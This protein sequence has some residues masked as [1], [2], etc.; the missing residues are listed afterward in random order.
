VVTFGYIGLYLLAAVWARA[1]NIDS[2]VLVWFPPA[3][4]AIAG[5]WFFG[6]RLLPIAIVAELLS[7]IFVFDV[8]T[9]FGASGL[10]VNCTLIPV[11]YGLGAELLRW[12]HFDP[13][14]ARFHDALAFMGLG[15][16][17]ASA[18]ASTLGIAVQVALGIVPRDEWAT[19]AAVFFVGDVVGIAGV[20]PVLLIVG[21]ALRRKAPFPL[22]DRVRATPGDP[23]VWA[24]VTRRDVLVILEV[25]APSVIAVILM[26]VGREPLQFLYLTFVPVMI[27]ALRHG[28]VG[29]VLST[30]A[31]CAVMTVG[32]DVQAVGTLE[33]SDFQ[34]LMAVLTISGIVVGSV[35][36]ERSA[37]LERQRRL[38]A[39]IE[40]TPDL[41][42]TATIDGTIEYVNPIGRKMLG[43]ESASDAEGMQV[44]DLFADELSRSLLQEA[45]VAA[46]RDGTWT[47]EN[48]IRAGD[49]REVPVSLVVIAHPEPD[50]RVRQV[51]TVLR[52]I[53][54]HRL[55]EDQLRRAALYDDRTRM[56]NR[57]LLAEHLGQALASA[58][59]DG[60][61]TAV[62]LVDID[63]FSIVNESLGYD[64]GDEV[65]AAFASRLREHRRPHEFVARHGDD[66]FAVVA[67]V[68]DEFDATRLAQR[69]LALF[70]EPF[71]TSARPLVLS[72]SAGILVAGWS[73]TEAGSSGEGAGR[74]TGT[75]AMDALRGA[76]VAL[77]R[78]KERGGGRVQLFD[79]G[80]D[81]RAR[82]RLELEAD[83][84]AAI[85]DESWEL[86]YQPIIETHSE[87][88]VSCE[89]LLRWTH[90]DRGA[91]S[92]FEVVRVAEATGLILPLGSSIMAR[93]CRDGRASRELG[94]DIRMGVNVSGVQLAEPEFLSRVEHALDE[95]GLPPSDL[96]IEVTETVLAADTAAAAEVLGGVR[97]LGCHVAMDDFGTGY[98]SLG[99]LREL[100]IDIL[101]LDRTFITD[102]TSSA[103]SAATVEAVIRLAD[104]LDL[105]VVAEGVEHRAQFTALR[106]M[107]CHRMQGWAFAPALPHEELQGLLA[108]ASPWATA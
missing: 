63:R 83:L 11:A 30:G 49:G 22:S 20:A 95:S 100:P 19:S 44:R 99:S 4:V 28:V 92:P 47:G 23:M 77:H 91:I 51:S 8:G 79:A 96:V 58:E 90:P 102:L 18:L 34:A 73:R 10:I 93:A 38:G 27:V 37:T 2:S 107:G 71:A 82:D 80:M 9:L 74:A 5:F 48:T 53:S 26:E 108:E 13:S 105:L 6:W 39:I 43:I 89:A 72:A 12:S 84:R 98:S 59:Q 56:P 36:S 87:C 1:F 60:A 25:L 54:P 65:L 32:A 40:A 41:V 88:I 64:I 85:D 21:D 16:V 14:F 31:L 7:S 50:G 101:K 69:Y 45:V 46:T 57:A 67:A 33:R 70:R 62:V 42:G 103:R 17:A 81:R 75:D 106:D 66:Q 3:G 29:A 24:G 68:Q 61:L 15:V 52:D 35:V 97:E 78:A 104:A 55:L 86:A 94:H 76:E